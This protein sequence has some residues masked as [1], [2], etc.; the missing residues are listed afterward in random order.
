MARPLA[1]VSIAWTQATA[2]GETVR[3]QLSG[4]ESNW[5]RVSE[6]AG[7]QRGKGRC[8]C[9]SYGNGVLRAQVPRVGC[10]RVCVLVTY[11]CDPQEDPLPH[12]TSH[13]EQAQDQRVEGR[14]N[15]LEGLPEGSHRDGELFVDAPVRLGR[16]AKQGANGRLAVAKDVGKGADLE[17]GAQKGLVL[18]AAA[19]R[20]LVDREPVLRS[21]ARQG[22]LLDR[23]E[24]GRQAQ[25][26]LKV[27][28]GAHV[29]HALANLLEDGDDDLGE[30][31]LGFEPG[32]EVQEEPVRHLNREH[33]KRKR[34]T[35][36]ISGEGKGKDPRA[37]STHLVRDERVVQLKDPPLLLLL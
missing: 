22:D 35:G 13:L 9:W 23:Q 14:L 8:H 31:L 37:T 32:R 15:Q 19:A 33:A 17:E 21:H 16:G 4:I 25:R 18:D 34:V 3:S 1:F 12:L 24:R 7:C 29:H 30:N 20:E 2:A 11:L 36:Q 27:P 26:F 10:V 5:E 28:Q 6:R